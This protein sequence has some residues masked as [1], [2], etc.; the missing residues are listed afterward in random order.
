MAAQSVKISWPRPGEHGEPGNRPAMRC[1]TLPVLKIRIPPRMLALP[2]SRRPWNGPVQHRREPGPAQQWQ[3]RPDQH[4]DNRSN[5][6]LSSSQPAHPCE[7]LTQL[8]A[9]GGVDDRPL[10]PDAPA[11]SRLPSAGRTAV[12]CCRDA[13][14]AGWDLEPGRQ[15]RTPSGAQLGLAFLP[16]SGSLPAAARREPQR[17]GC[18]RQPASGT[19]A[20]CRTLTQRPSPRR[21]PAPR[22]TAA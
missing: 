9:G 20:S 7:Q 6:V 14:P 5:G 21:L 8:D 11:T 2:Y 15:V 10:R 1:T 22:M 16:E 18:G 19:E 13:E 12:G 4:P 3:Q 17:L